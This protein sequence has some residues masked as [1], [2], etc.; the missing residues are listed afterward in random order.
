[1]TKIWFDMDGTIAN[2]YGVAGWE[3][4]LNAENALPYWEA[5]PLVDV[6]EL[7]NIL[8]TFRFYGVEVGV[9]TWGAM[10]ATADY[11][12]Q[13]IVAKKAWLNKYFPVLL[14]DFNFTRYGVDKFQTCG[15]GVLVDDNADVRQ[16]WNGLTINAKDENICEKLLD[17]LDE[18]L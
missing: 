6:E 11:D 10:F 7:N 9:I 18:L 12:H 13:T 15:Y 5:K 14:E 16:T 17:L 4:M 2:L 1:M 8:A 3:E